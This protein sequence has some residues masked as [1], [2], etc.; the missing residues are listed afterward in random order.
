MD[1]RIRY[2]EEI[3]IEIA[4]Q[5]ALGY[6]ARAVATKLVLPHETMRVWEDSYRQS[7]L[8]NSSNVRENRT[9]PEHPKVAAVENFLSEHLRVK[10]FLSLK[11]VREPFIIFHRVGVRTSL[12]APRRAQVS[13]VMQNKYLLNCI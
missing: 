2:S 6:G 5:F 11:L 13:R 8:L 9:Y 3:R 10:L 1:G 7:C 12:T 4:R